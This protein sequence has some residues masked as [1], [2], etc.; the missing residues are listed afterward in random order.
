MTTCIESL[1][2][3]PTTPLEVFH[4]FDVTY[5][6]PMTLIVLALILGVIE[7]AIYLR[8]RSLAML[9]ILGFYTISAFSSIMLSPYISSQYHIALYVI[10]LGA[11]SAFTVAIL[12]LVKE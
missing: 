7:I 4:A 3:P 6:A 5:G 12:K 2:C 10:A 9:S 8:T 11:S 1:G